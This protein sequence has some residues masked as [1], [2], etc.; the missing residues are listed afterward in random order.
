MCAQCT[1]SR[2]AGM[3]LI[4]S[5]SRGMLNTVSKGGEGGGVRRKLLKC[6]KDTEGVACLPC[7]NQPSL[8]SS[9]GP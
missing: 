3:T 7:D 8:I 5:I 1:G 4:L 6:E 2:S 9:Y